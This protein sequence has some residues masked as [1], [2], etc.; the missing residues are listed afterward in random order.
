MS[1]LGRTRWT[2]SRIRVL[3]PALALAGLMTIAPLGAAAATAPW[4]D[5]ETWMLSLINCNRSGRL[6]SA[7]GKC[8]GSYGQYSTPVPAL[9]RH[10]GLSDNVARPYARQLARNGA[11]THYFNSTDPGLRIS[12][13]GYRA[14][15]WGENIGCRDGYATVR[16]AVLASHRA[17]Q[18]E[19]SYNGGHWKNIKNKAFKYVGIGIWRYEGQARLVT[20]F[21]TPLT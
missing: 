15:N 14:A 2:R 12:V 5:L 10:A 19:R 21:F 18:A 8:Y 20:D 17:F 4:Y 16:A 13:A 7:T 3:A 6:V 9:R 1:I 11:C